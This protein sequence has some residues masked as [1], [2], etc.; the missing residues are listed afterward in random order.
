MCA[1]VQVPRVRAC[2]AD[3][4]RQRG[5]QVEVGAARGGV[6]AER[7]DI[8]G[9]RGARQHVE[10][11]EPDVVHRRVGQ[12]RLAGLAGELRVGHLGADVLVHHLGLGQDAH[13]LRHRHVRLLPGA[14]LHAHR[15]E[16]CRRG[17]VATGRAALAQRRHLLSRHDGV[18]DL[19]HLRRARRRHMLRAL[20]HQR[21]HREDRARK[22]PRLHGEA[23]GLTQRRDEE[24]LDLD[25]VRGLDRAT[26]QQLVGLEH[27]RADQLDHFLAVLLLQQLVHEWHPRRQRRRLEVAQPPRA[28]QHLS[29][30]QAPTGTA[31]RRDRHE[32]LHDGAHRAGAVAHLG[33]EVQRAAGR[34][35]VEERQSGPLEPDGLDLARRRRVL[36][37]HA[38]FERVVLVG[39]VL[40]LKAE[41]VVHG[42]A[43]LDA[44]A[45]GGPDL[46]V[47]HH[48]RL[49][50]VAA[51][52]VV[53]DQIDHRHA[54]SSV[55]RA[56]E[57][58]RVALRREDARLGRHLEVRLIVA[59]GDDIHRRGG[60]RRVEG[61]VKLA[62]SIRARASQHDAVE[63]V[64]TH[65]SV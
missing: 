17:R 51:R 7:R 49:A 19:Q 26:G 16:Q 28:A 1:Q 43:L 3:V 18:H 47:A 29:I 48:A 32:V 6:V 61:P 41:L 57:R 24:G 60:E 2:S 54:H 58:D 50:Q 38:E 37:P 64:E 5:R 59:E 44:V 35:V 25:G 55:D 11:V 63:S 31:G 65:G 10:A 27:Q 30:D 33:H 62:L 53:A 45:A 23:L 14:P 40:A 9:Q 12:H 56:R 13:H 42:H 22:V 4:G 21:R 20:R 34:A 8:Q 39:P 36:E 15:V 46:A 52:R